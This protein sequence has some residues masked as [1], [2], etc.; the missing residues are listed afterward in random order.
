MDAKNL[1]ILMSDE[2]DPRYMGCAGHSFV[3]TPNMDRLAKSGTRFETAY[4]PSPICVPA[5]GSFATGRPVHQTGC[6]DNA[7]GY[8]GTIPGWGQRLIETGHRVESIGKLHYRNESN[9]TG[10]SV[11]HSPMHLKQGVGTVWGAIKEPFADLPEPWRM[12]NKIGAGVSNYNLYDRKSANTACEWLKARANSADDKPW[13]LYVGFVAPHYPL[14]VPSQYL[15][16]Y[17]IE[18]IPLPKL[19]PKDGY[20]RHPWVESLDALIGQDHFFKSDEERLHAIAAYLALCSFVDAEIGIVL[21]AIRDNGFEDTTRIVYTSDHGDNM[22][23]RGLWGKSVL[24]EESTRI[25]MIVSGPD[26]PRDQVS[27]TPVTLLDIHPTAI[28]GLGQAIHEADIDLMGKSIFEIASSQNDPNRLVTSEY[29]AMGA[30]SSAF[31]LRQGEWKYHYYEGYAPELFNLL[32]DPEELSDRANDPAS[33][34]ILAEFEK[35]LHRMVEPTKID[36]AAKDSMAALIES[37]GGR[38]KAI[39]L[40]RSGSTPVPGQTPE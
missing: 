10:F 18:D 36:R 35:L 14:I 31:M 34:A 27:K 9:A 7:H 29:H 16:M 24:Y 8:D 19:R 15:E 11:Q 25:P 23:A 32:E 39:D 33:K 1:L 38:E 12:F 37:Y 2:H 5:R 17:P 22:G 40:G 28:S 13:V 26:I 21:D 20:L 4:T 30:P 3:K 6:W